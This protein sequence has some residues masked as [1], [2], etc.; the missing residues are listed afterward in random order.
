MFPVLAA[1]VL[2][3]CVACGPQSV[4]R[5]QTTGSTPSDATSSTAP[6]PTPTPTAA[7]LD[8]DGD[9]RANLEFFAATVEGVWAEARSVASADYTT[10]LVAAGFDVA[11]MERTADATTVGNPADSIQFS[12]LWE[13]ECLV[14]QVGP[15]IARPV[16]VVLP[17]LPEGGCLVGNTPAVEG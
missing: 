7:A 6:T 15:S 2:T 16:A 14:G 13:G 12:V 11:A 3:L 17:E 5:V 1:A 9:A 8:P 4:P 10:A